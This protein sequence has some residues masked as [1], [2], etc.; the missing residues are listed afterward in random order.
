MISVIRQFHDGMLACVRLDDRVCSGWFAV[1]QGLRQD[2]RARSW[3]SARLGLTVLEA[4]TEIMR[5][6]AKGMPK[7]TAIISGDAAGQVYDQT[8]EF[9]YLG[10]NFK[11][12]ADLSI[13]VDQRIRN[14][15]C[16]SRKYA[17]ELNDGPSAPLEPK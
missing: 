3:S 2:V 14:V 6:S 11:H 5:L 10:G 7:S 4:K 16:S 12:D 17:L 13:E 1:E 15:W 8:N 9:V